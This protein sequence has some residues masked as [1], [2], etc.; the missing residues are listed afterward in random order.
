MTHSGKCTEQDTHRKWQNSECTRLRQGEE[1]PSQEVGKC[2][3][4]H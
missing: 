3:R 2:T 1:E 4:K